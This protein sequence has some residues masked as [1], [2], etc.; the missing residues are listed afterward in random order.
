MALSGAAH[1]NQTEEDW[2]T[3][4]ALGQGWGL[5]VPVRDPATGADTLAASTLILPYGAGT[6]AAAFAWIS[7]VLVLPAWRG[8]GFAQ[9]LLRCAVAEL[10]AR[11]VL[12]VLDATP[13]GH[14]VYVRE[15]FVDCWGFARWRGKLGAVS[16]LPHN[17]VL[18]VRR[19]SETDWPAVDELDSAAFGASRLPLLRA[20]ARRT[21]KLAWV[22]WLA[23]GPQRP[24]GY[25]LGRDGRTALQ[26]G[27]LVAADPEVAIALLA[28]GL[29]PAS[30]QARRNACDIVVDVRDGQPLV[31][32]WLEAHGFAIERPFTRMVRAAYGSAPGESA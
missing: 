18:G 15:G 8:R 29:G 3:M 14:P 5:R 17:A 11:G 16:E 6:A 1:W 2:R 7:M 25:L 26:L 22:A 23:E 28:A 30:Q 20:L 24:L 19:L 9:R 13:A 12:A 10:D 31:T 27:P 4:L 32:R 21:P